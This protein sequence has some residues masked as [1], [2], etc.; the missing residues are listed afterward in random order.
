VVDFHNKGCLAE[1]LCTEYGKTLIL[2]VQYGFYRRNSV[3]ELIGGRARDT[4][5]RGADTTD[6]IVCD[7]SFSPPMVFYA[8]HGNPSVTKIYHFIPLAFF[9][10]TITLI[11]K[12]VVLF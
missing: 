4:V 9:P 6:L 8:G 5:E 1:T 10:R 7:T 12:K 11:L 2:P 3:E